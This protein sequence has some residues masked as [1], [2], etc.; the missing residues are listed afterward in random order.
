MNDR[1]PNH[2]RISETAVAERYG[3]RPRTIQRWHEAD[4]DFP[5][6]HLYRGRRHYWFDELQRWEAI[7]PE[8]A[9]RAA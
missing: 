5:R 8:L 6:S 9:E 4:K 7:N 1:S 3:V 2:Y